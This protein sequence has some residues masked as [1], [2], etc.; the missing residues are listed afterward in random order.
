MPQFYDFHISSRWNLLSKRYRKK[1]PLC[2][3]DVKYGEDRRLWGCA[4]AGRV[5][6]AEEVDHI[7]PDGD[8][9]AESNL[10]SICSHC[11][12]WKNLRERNKP[13][14]ELDSKGRRIR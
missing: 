5:R 1:H 12:S 3:H 7:D 6:R 2:E 11:H 14:I 8:R 13:I 10:Q 4:A 9:W